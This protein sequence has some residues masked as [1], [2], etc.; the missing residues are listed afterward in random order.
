MSILQEYEEI[1][2]EMGYTRYDAIGEYL[3]EVNKDRKQELFLSDVLY[4]ES[5][6]I[7]FDEWFNERIKPFRLFN[8]ENRT[9]SVLLDQ[10]NFCYDWVDEVKGHSLYG[11]GHCYND[12]FNDYLEKNYNELNN[13]L[14]YD[15]ENGMFDVDS[16]DMRIA[17]SVAWI[18]SKLYNNEKK[19]I[20]LIKETK[21]KYNYQ[22]NIK[23]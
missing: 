15:S 16:D 22:F 4:K 23:I 20:E 14:S 19:M 17:D 9:Y 1:R 7:K 10:S 8:Y 2:K 3:D 18:L 6:Y 5:E 21:E 12:L 13:Q 11:D